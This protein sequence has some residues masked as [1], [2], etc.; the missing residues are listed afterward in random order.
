MKPMR[1]VMAEIVTTDSK[2]RSTL[3]TD[4]WIT[5][6][7]QIELDG[8]KL[9]CNKENKLKMMKVTE[10]ARFVL[11]NLITLSEQNQAIEEER[12]KNLSDTSDGNSVD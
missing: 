9:Q 3:M 2:L 7:D 5:D 12:V 6:W 10:F 11:D 4:Y 1:G 8:T